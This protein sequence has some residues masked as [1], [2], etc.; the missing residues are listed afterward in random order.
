MFL[1]VVKALAKMIGALLIGA[2]ISIL[3][4]FVLE[5]SCSR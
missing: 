4:L 1:A 3:A 5:A 2:A